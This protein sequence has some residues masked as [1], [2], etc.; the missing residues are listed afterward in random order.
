MRKPRFHLT[1]HAAMTLREIHAHS[2]K[3]W[4][5]KTADKYMAE[6]YAVM[7]KAAT[8]P[9]IGKLRAPRAVPFLMVPAGKHFVVYDRPKRDVIILAILHQRRNIE[10]VIADMGPAFLAEIKILRRELLE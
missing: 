2:T 5:Q 8:K 10:R 9:D 4:G 7:M 6:I 1:R 3:Q